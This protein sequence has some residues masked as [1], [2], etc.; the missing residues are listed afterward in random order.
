MM[1][2]IDVFMTYLLVVNIGKISG[3]L[4]VIILRKEP[5]VFVFYLETAKN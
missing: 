3:D 4:K 2:Y 5:I 1:R